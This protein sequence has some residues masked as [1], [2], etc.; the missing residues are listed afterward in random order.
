MARASTFFEHLNHHPE[1]HAQ[2]MDGMHFMTESLFRLWT[3]IDNN[4]QPSQRNVALRALYKT[5]G[6]AKAYEDIMK[7][8][9]FDLVYGNYII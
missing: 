1:M 5:E 6:E 7:A 3:V 8:Q 2:H 4:H 9:V